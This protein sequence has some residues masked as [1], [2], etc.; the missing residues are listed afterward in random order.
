MSEQ[1]EFP[2]LPYNGTGGF[3]KGSPTSQERAM[4]EAS[5]GALSRRQ[6]LVLA[7]LERCGLTGATWQEA[8]EHLELHHGQISGALSNL[9]RAG[10]V[11]QIYTKRNKCLPYV[12]SCYR[13]YFSDEARRD[14]VLTRRTPDKNEVGPLVFAALNAI[15]DEYGINYESLRKI[16]EVEALGKVCLL[17]AMPD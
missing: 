1:M 14:T 8:G 10:L 16:P 12:H 3:A 17:P 4:R 2:I 5:S 6:R 7:Y 11:F 9:H 13:P 15:A